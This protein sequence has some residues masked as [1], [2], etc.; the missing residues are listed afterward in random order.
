MRVWRLTTGSTFI[1]SGISLAKLKR[2]RI[3]R[4]LVVL[5]GA[6]LSRRDPAA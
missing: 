5:S 2:Q 3:E 6:K 4:Y 1:R